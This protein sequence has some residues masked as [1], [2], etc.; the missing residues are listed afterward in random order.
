MFKG[1]DKG[2]EMEEIM[3]LKMKSS[4]S[5]FFLLLLV[6]DKKGRHFTMCQNHISPFPD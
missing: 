5:L 4:Q 6:A 3:A 2:I 1:C